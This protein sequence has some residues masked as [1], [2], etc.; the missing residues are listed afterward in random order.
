MCIRDRTS[1]WRNAEEIAPGMT[2]LVAAGEVFAADGVI[3]AGNSSIDRAL[4]TGRS[5]GTVVNGGF[6]CYSVY[7]T[8]DGGAMA[9]GAVEV[10]FFAALCETLGLVNGPARQYDRAAQPDLRAEIAA[11]FRQRTRDAWVAAF[12]QVEACVT[13]ILTIDELAADEHW[14]ARE[15]FA[16]YTHPQKGPATQLAAF[17]RGD[18]RGDGLAQINDESSFRAFLSGLTFTPAEI[19]AISAGKIAGWT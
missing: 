16:S 10:K 19:D 14:R 3:I 6:A 12:D 1:E 9:V 4:V 5:E 17:G 18:G 8:Q 13:P 11:I 7:A 15:V 2:L